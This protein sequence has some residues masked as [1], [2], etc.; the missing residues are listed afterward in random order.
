LAAM[1][2][3]AGAGPTELARLRIAD[4]D[5]VGGTVLLIFENEARLVP[6][7]PALHFVLQDWLAH[8]PESESDSMFVTAT[9]PPLPRSG[10]EQAFGGAAARLGAGRSLSTMLLDFFRAQIA[11]SSDGDAYKYLL[12]TS[13]RA[14]KT[15]RATMRDVRNLIAAT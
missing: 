12:G 15:S 11:K 7:T 3:L 8:R 5:I 9:G 10:I 2:A 1:H 4:F 14:V 13:P 6:T